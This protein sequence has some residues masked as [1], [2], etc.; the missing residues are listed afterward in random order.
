MK[1]LKKKPIFNFI[2]FSTNSLHDA[3]E[4]YP[5]V[6]FNFSKPF[7]ICENGFDFDKICIKLLNAPLYNTDDEENDV[8]PS[9]ISDI[10]ISYINTKDFYY[11]RKSRVKI[12]YIDSKNN[13]SS[14]KY[15]NFDDI[16]SIRPDMCVEKTIYLTKT[17]NKT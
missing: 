17:K 1:K 11:W 9:E 6:S 8:I 15:V 16:H 13:R 5:F 7:P 10:C 4:S 3:S 12:L 2:L 14:Y